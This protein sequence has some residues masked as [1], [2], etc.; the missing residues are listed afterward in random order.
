MKKKI[1]QIQHAFVDAQYK[2]PDMNSHSE[3]TMSEAQRV[4]IRE[5]DWTLH[6]MDVNGV[7]KFDER[8]ATPRLQTH[9]VKPGTAILIGPIEKDIIHA[10]VIY[11]PRSLGT[12]SMICHILH[13]GRGPYLEAL[14]TGTVA[15]MV[16]RSREK[17]NRMC[18]YNPTKESY[19]IK[20]LELGE[21]QTISAGDIVLIYKTHE[22]PKRADLVMGMVLSHSKEIMD[23]A[24]G[25][26]WQRL[27]SYTHNALLRYWQDVSNPLSAN[28]YLRSLGI[29][30]PPV[31]TPT[32]SLEN[33]NAAYFNG[34]MLIANVAP[35]GGPQRNAPVPPNPRGA[36]PSGGNAP[37]P[38]GAVP[39]GGNAQMPP[40]T[41]PN[42]SSIVTAI[43][44]HPA[45]PNAPTPPSTPAVPGTFTFGAPR[46]VSR[47]DDQQ[48]A[49]RSKPA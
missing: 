11:T 43:P 40:I 39:S 6:A 7:D 20:F 24:D 34:L 35:G 12:D 8:Y 5:N 3:D 36:V 14:R 44:V 28:T 27:L 17:L 23:Q 45:A 31:R 18:V 37:N 25:F 21:M 16:P 29:I 26:K 13:S 41:Q 42:F 49:K 47:E 19:G 9:S 15:V 10:K 2:W 1:P 22:A 46:V 33:P 38:R 48:P 30:Y 32:M 4:G